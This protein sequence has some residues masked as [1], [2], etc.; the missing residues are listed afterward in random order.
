IV[1]VSIGPAGSM[2]GSCAVVV[3]V[4]SKCMVRTL[5]RLAVLY[6]EESCGQCTTCREGTVWLAR[7]LHSIV[8]G[9]GRPE[10]IDTL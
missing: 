8:A 9:E 1:F 5:A 6:Y 7:S 3:L 10:D 4:D 2:L